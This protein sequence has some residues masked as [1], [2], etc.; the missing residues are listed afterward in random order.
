MLLRRK[1]PLAPLHQPFNQKTVAAM[2]ETPASP[3]KQFDWKQKTLNYVPAP[4][5]EF[6][7]LLVDPDLEEREIFIYHTVA[8]DLGGDYWVDGRLRFFMDNT[9]VGELPIN[10]A[11]NV[12]AGRFPIETG[13][14]LF[15]SHAPESGGHR[16]IQM[17]RPNGF[18]DGPEILTG[19]SIRCRCNAIAYFIGQ[20]TEVN[21]VISGD[22][23]LGVLSTP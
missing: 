18:A 12:S 17:L 16:F 19:Q 6:F 14:N 3:T 5:K 10:L 13:V 21:T 23:F 20:L 9:P 1:I 8:T 4:N 11:N 2:S 15:P 22:L 7:R